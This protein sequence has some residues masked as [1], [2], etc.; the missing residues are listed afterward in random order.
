MKPLGALLA[1]LLAASASTA[2][3]RLTVDEYA[4]RLQAIRSALGD[5]RL[6]DARS[7][8]GSLRSARI[9]LGGELLAT[10]TSLLAAVEA[11]ADTAQ[12]AALGRRIAVLEKSL[13]RSSTPPGPAASDRALLERLRAEQTP[14]PIEKGGLVAELALRPLSFPE[15]VLAALQSAR[16][17]LGRGLRR[18][19]KLLLKLWPQPRPAAPEA[20]AFNL[21]LGVVALVAIVIAVL[22]VLAYRAL[23][24]SPGS[25]GPAR[26][27]ALATSSSDE[28]PL[29]READEWER[30]AAEL[31]AAGRRREAIRAFYHAVL[32]A[33]FRC[34]ALHYRKSL[35]N[36]EY[37]SAVPPEARFRPAFLELTRIF[38]R[39]WYGHDQSPAEALARSA[40]EARHI[41]KAIRG[42]EA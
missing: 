39:E 7:G 28:N 1:V 22:G 42:A 37:A 10:D 29:S 18:L 15:R 23:R 38:D 30:Y 9:V 32:M 5:G 3:E 20:S 16:E 19:L 34:G 25:P 17:W 11:V 13:P 36:W 12:A 33:L 31:A 6:E 4:V 26:S 8:A 40:Q 24:R 41:L 21:N 2:Q 35:T 27:Q 14:R